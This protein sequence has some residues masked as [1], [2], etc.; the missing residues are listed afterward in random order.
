VL[1][2]VVGTTSALYIN[3]IAFAAA[4]AVGGAVVA[5]LVFRCL[6][7]PAAATALTPL[8]AGAPIISLGY[9]FVFIPVAI[10]TF[11]LLF[12]SIYF[13]LCLCHNIH[14]SL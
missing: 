12:F 3:D 5:M 11:C 1:S 9:G 14:R 6:H 8:L 7:P 10:N 13:F 4:I 2:A